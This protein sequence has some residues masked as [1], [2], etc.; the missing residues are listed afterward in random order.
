MWD[1]DE[2]Q[3]RR[4]GHAE[5]LS[6]WEIIAAILLGLAAWSGV[7]ALTADPAPPPV[8]ESVERRVDEIPLVLRS[9]RPEAGV[10]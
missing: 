8:A 10:H 2:C 3:R 7:Q 6:S 5:L 1:D 4:L 9:V